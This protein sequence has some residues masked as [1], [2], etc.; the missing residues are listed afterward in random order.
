MIRNVY[1]TK[2]PKGPSKKTSKEDLVFHPGS[3]AVKNLSDEIGNIAGAIYID[4][5]AHLSLSSD[6][7]IEWDKSWDA[8][9]SL[10]EA[11]NRVVFV[12]E[13]IELLGRDGEAYNA[14][15][16]VADAIKK[17]RKKRNEKYKTSIR[18]LIATGINPSGWVQPDDDFI[19][20]LVNKREQLGV[21]GACEEMGI[22]K[23]T[24][25][26]WKKKYKF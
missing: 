25:Y 1:L 3:V 23:Q 26:R 13:G 16:G 21:I 12:A 14:L 18:E 20:L 2:N 8:V 10:L 11:G 6:K 22:S 5:L 7:A 17:I 15:R 4:D 19:R 24:Y 9:E